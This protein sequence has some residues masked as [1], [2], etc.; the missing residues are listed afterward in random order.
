MHL[1][2]TLRNDTW[3]IVLTVVTELKGCSRS[4]AVTYDKHVVISR[5]RCKTETWLARRALTEKL[6]WLLRTVLT[7]L[8]S[9]FIKIQHSNGINKTNHE[10]TRLNLLRRLTDVRL[11]FPKN[12]FNARGIFLIW[13]DF[14][15][16]TAFTYLLTVHQQPAILSN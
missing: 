2:T 9:A 5:R 13:F 16:I 8:S 1:P 14:A 6:Q 15:L 7:I 12:W 3:T 4:Q 11:H 10:T